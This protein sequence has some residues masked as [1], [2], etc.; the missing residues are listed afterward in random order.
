MGFRLLDGLLLLNH[1]TAGVYSTDFTIPISKRTDH[2]SFEGFQSG[3]KLLYTMPR[4]L[5]LDRTSRDICIPMA[6]VSVFH[7]SGLLEKRAT[8]AT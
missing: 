8:P 4:G 3:F 6:S 2:P 5:Q 1:A 7:N